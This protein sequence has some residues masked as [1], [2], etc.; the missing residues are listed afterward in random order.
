M[1]CPP[2]TFAVLVIELDSF[3]PSS[4]FEICGVPSEKFRSICSAVDKLD[5]E[6]WEAVKKEM[7]EEKGRASRGE[8]GG[9]GKAGG[10]GGG[11]G[12]RVEEKEEGGTERA[13]A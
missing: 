9:V 5:K 11:E 7:T 3:L 6:S 12:G 2:F 4:V 1:A 8:E 13:R 10:M